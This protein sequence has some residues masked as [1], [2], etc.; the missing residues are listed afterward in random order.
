VAVRGLVAVGVVVTGELARVSWLVGALEAECALWRWMVDAEEEW[1][2]AMAIGSRGGGRQ[3]HALLF[4]FRGLERE[5][6][7]VGRGLTALLFAVVAGD[8]IIQAGGVDRYSRQR[9]PS[10]LSSSLSL[11]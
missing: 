10:P 2:D 1:S 6:G 5:V 9:R 8:D 11:L 4:P 3:H 7:R